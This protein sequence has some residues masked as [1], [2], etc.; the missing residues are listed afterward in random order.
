MSYLSDY[1]ADIASGKWGKDKIT[2]QVDTQTG[3]VLEEKQ[4]IVKPENVGEKMA[5]DDKQIGNKTYTI[6]SNQESQKIAMVV[7]SI[8]SEELKKALTLLGNTEIIKAI[9]CDMAA[10]YLKLC[11]DYLPHSTVVVDKFHV[12]KYVIEALQEVRIRIKKD[13]IKELPKGKDRKKSVG[14]LSHLEQL[15]RCRF[16]LNKSR[17]KWTSEQTKNIESLFEKYE[18]LKNAYELTEKFR[19]W[20]HHSNQGKHRIEIEKAL[21]EWYEAVEKSKLDEFKSAKKMLEKHEV[22]IINY[23]FEKIT[24]AKAERLNGKIERFVS[25]NYGIKNNDFVLYRIIGYFA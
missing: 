7:E 21:F 12:F 4:V 13:R 22:E 18:D 10:S 17:E 5:I 20:Y 9:S 3:E 15:Q 8:K 25:N 2:V 1:E 24:S 14:E 23:F 19:A 11:S 16:A 6:L